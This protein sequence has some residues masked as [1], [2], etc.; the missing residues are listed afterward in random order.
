[1]TGEVLDRSYGG[2]PAGPAAFREPPAKRPIQ[3]RGGEARAR[4]EFGAYRLFAGRRPEGITVRELL[5]TANTSPG[6]I[7]SHYDS[8]DR[9]V[10]V[11]VAGMSSKVVGQI[12]EVAP[13]RGTPRQLVQRAAIHA[14]SVVATSDYRELLMV[15][16]REP[17]RWKAV[18]DALAAALRECAKRTLQAASPAVLLHQDALDAFADELHMRLALRPMLT[19]QDPSPAE[20]HDAAARAAAELLK[21]VFQP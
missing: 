13:T 21:G 1:V 17:E 6:F 19:R 16:V 9:L 12:L 5:G 3:T 14:A 15:C 8:I 18:L 7:K 20:V 2:S 10:E 4:V 11:A